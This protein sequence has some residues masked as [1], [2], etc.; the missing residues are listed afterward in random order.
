MKLLQNDKYEMWSKDLETALKAQ[1]SGKVNQFLRQVNIKLQET[2][3]FAMSAS[4]APQLNSP[5][6][7]GASLALTE[8][9]PWSA[10]IVR[11]GLDRFVLKLKEK[12]I[13]PITDEAAVITQLRR[14]RAMDLFSSWM[15]S[16]KQTAV[17]ETY[18]NK[19]RR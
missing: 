7:T 8:A 17:I 3:L 10:G 19:L 16:E 11:D 4:T 6:A 14:E 9:A 5:V 12:K 18:I 2:G 15:D 13:T 1:D